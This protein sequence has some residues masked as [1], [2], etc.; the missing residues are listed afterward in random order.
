MSVAV[1]HAGVMSK[2]AGYNHKISGGDYMPGL[3][4]FFN[5]KYFSAGLL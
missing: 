3:S 5:E 1:F 2:R 4:I